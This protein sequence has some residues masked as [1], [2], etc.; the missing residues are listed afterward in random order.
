MSPEVKITGGE[1]AGIPGPQEAERV[2]LLISGVKHTALI[3]RDEI[4]ERVLRW[5]I[6]LSRDEDARLLTSE[7]PR[8]RDLVAVAHK[9]RPGVCFCV[10]VPP[11]SQWY[12][13]HPAVLHVYETN[14]PPLEQHF[15]DQHEAAPLGATV[16]S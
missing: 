1:P 10:P 2:Y 7:V 12:N 16:P 13:L 3:S 11:E 15:R 8:W 4:A 14:D 9:L 5:H 6:S